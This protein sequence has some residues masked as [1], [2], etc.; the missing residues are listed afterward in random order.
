MPSV[1][2]RSLPEQSTQQW[3]VMNRNHEEVLKY[4]S[5]LSTPIEPKVFAGLWSKTQND[6]QSQ[7]I[8]SELDKWL[9]DNF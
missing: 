4:L 3:I 1:H 7:N 8:A 2:K 6:K 5:A 9:N